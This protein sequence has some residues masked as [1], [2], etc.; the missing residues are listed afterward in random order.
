MRDVNG[1][2]NGF[3]RLGLPVDE[4]LT[5][6]SSDQWTE[7]KSVGLRSLCLHLIYFFG[8]KVKQKWLKVFFYFVL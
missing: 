7:P 3:S 2:Y 5:E 8:S 6:F 4:R 1:N